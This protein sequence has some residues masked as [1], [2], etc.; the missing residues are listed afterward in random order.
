MDQTERDLIA[1]AAQ[2][3]T[4]GERCERFKLQ[5]CAGYSA[6]LRWHE[7]DIAFESYILTEIINSGHYYIIYFFIYYII[8]FVIISIFLLI[9]LQYPYIFRDSEN[10]ISANCLDTQTHI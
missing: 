5:V 2:L 4:R 1:Q 10:F 7:I 3:N 8:Y 6:R 9:I